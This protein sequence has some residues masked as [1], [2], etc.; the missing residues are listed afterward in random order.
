MRRKNTEKYTLD[1]IGKEYNVC[2][3]RIR[4][5]EESGMQK[6]KESAKFI[7]KEAFKDF[8][9][10]IRSN[11]GVRREDTLVSELA[12]S[13][14]R[15]QA[16]FLLAVGGRFQRF[17][18]TEEFFPFWSVEPD[19]KKKVRSETESFIKF[20]E[21]K[22]QPVFLGEY[23]KERGRKKTAEKT[24]SSCLEISKNIL[25]NS[26]EQY[27]LPIWPEINPRGAKD[28]AHLVLRQENRPLH[29][30]NVAEAIGTDIHPQ[31]VHNELIKDPR[32]VLV[33]RGIY[34]LKDWGYESGPVRQIIHNAL[35][36]AKSPL[37]KSEILNKVLKQRMV[38]ENTVL[39]NLNNKKYFLRD[40]RGMYYLR[41]A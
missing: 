19:S 41:E 22:K 25:K 30:K 12:S 38:K 8:E 23:L 40:S 7:C 16:L 33:G 6:A 39:L 1:K 28:K 21:Q 11:G 31:T 20:L 35:K 10:T 32:F 34:A 3:E 18:E 14:L 5:I 36:T 24:I 4:Q 27:G 29:F 9:K 17:N 37:S 13:E 2:R 15:N 26:D